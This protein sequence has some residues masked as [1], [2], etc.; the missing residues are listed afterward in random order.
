MGGGLVGGGWGR[1][2]TRELTGSGQECHLT[3]PRH[4]ALNNDLLMMGIM[5]RFI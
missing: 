4:T 2:P 3:V 1:R 5:N